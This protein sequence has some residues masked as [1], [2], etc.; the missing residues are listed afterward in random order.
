MELFLTSNII[1]TSITILYC[2]YIKSSVVSKLI[3][4]KFALICWLLPL[5]LVRDY[6]PQEV[7]V[8]IQWLSPIMTAETPS[9]TVTKELSLFESISLSD[10]F[11]V[12]SIIGF[13]LF[14]IQLIKHRRWLNKLQKDSHSEFLYDYQGI[15]VRS[16]KHINNALLIGYSKPTIWINPELKNSDSLDIILQHEFVH[17]R[18]KDN[19]WLVLFEIAKSIYWWNPLVKLLVHNLKE[20]LETRCDYKASLFFNEGIYLKK[21][22]NLI[23]SN[24]PVSDTGFSSAAISNNSNI[25]RLK[26]LKEKQTMNQFSRI[27]IG[28]LIF[29]GVITL[30][31][32]ISSIKAMAEENELQGISL[33]FDNIKIESI[34][35]IVGDYFNLEVII[36]DEIKKEL[37]SINL[38]NIPDEK[39]LQVLTKILN[40]SFVQKGKQLIVSNLPGGVSQDTSKEISTLIPTVQYSIDK[41]KPND[42]GVFLDFNIKISETKEDAIRIE[43]KQF[44]MW[45]H[46]DKPTAIKI[47]D[48][49]ELDLTIKEGSED[50]ILIESKIYLI[51]SLE[52]KELIATPRLFT[53]NGN[54]ATIE[55]GEAVSSSK[56]PS[57]KIEMTPRKSL[58]SEIE[59]LKK[60][61]T[62]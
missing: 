47:G 12:T 35:E 13:L 42:I 23:V 52:E 31:F 11:L 60:K 10:I 36:D 18:N 33:N 49:L 41:P 53:T 26:Y 58:Y 29:T 40:V 21:L 59:K 43:E 25:R 4:S 44:Q 28:L 2:R 34:S 56:H 24:M 6:L 16:S 54:L 15:A 7:A 62:E 38:E 61:P 45:S 14:S 5:T 32:P 50:H 17:A 27:M 57:F 46:F 30:T 19:Y 8:N 9:F 55:M 22:T 37:V 3:L 39:A 51:I 48:R 1:I 20:Q